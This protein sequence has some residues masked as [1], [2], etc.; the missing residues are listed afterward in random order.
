MKFTII[1]FRGGHFEV[2]AR[3]YVLKCECLKKKK[4]LI[5]TMKTYLP[6]PTTDLRTIALHIDRRR[7]RYF[8]V[9]AYTYYI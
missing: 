6:S 7:R 9:P 5:I 2:R 4:R 3:A 1:T 8:R